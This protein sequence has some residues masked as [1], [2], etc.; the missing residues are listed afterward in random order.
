MHPHLHP[1]SL[2]RAHLNDLTLRVSGGDDYALN[3]VLLSSVLRPTIGFRFPWISPSAHVF[4]RPSD[5]ALTPESQR[6]GWAIARKPAG[7]G[8]AIEGAVLD[9]FRHAQLAVAPSKRRIWR[10]RAVMTRER[11]TL[12]PPR[13]PCPADPPGSS[14]APPLA[15]RCD[16][17]KDPTDGSSSARPREA[18]TY[19]HEP[20]RRGTRMDRDLKRKRA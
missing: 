5:R 16:R 15:D 7:S 1:S 3:L 8:L 17:A 2:L 6:R 20:D 4:G 19:R 14:A 10:S 18:N 12:E 9:D 13:A 11:I